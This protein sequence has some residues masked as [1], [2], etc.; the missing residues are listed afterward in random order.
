MTRV[1][2][3]AEATIS[4]AIEPRG[5][6]KA[7]ATSCTSADYHTCVGVYNSWPG[8]EISLYAFYQ[9]RKLEWCRGWW[10]VSA[11]LHVAKSL[12]QAKLHNITCR[13]HILVDLTGE[14][15]T[16]GLPCHGHG[17]LA[18]AVEKLWQRRA[19]Q[20]TVVAVPLQWIKNKWVVVIKDLRCELENS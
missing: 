17:H 19:I 14:V 7:C 12:I 16:S 2:F 5:S 11:S 10:D 20:A 9:T 15:R 8:N 13:F 6:G 1:G 18:A 3:T 4:Y